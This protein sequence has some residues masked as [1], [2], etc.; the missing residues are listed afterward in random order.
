MPSFGCYQM[1]SLC[2]VP[3][4][5]PGTEQT[6]PPLCGPHV[7]SRGH[8]CQVLSQR[9]LQCQPQRAQPL[10]LLGHSV[11]PDTEFGKIK[12]KQAFPPKWEEG[13]GP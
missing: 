13:P 12:E 1:P 5:G 11:S 3:A 2:W 6:W 9:L 4:T 7:L 8:A 10:P